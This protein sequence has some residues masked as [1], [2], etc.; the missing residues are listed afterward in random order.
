MAGFLHGFPWRLP[1]GRPGD[2]GLYGPGS[3]AW[4]VNGEAMLMLGGPRALLM[5]I[6][7]PAVAAAVAQFSGF[8]HDAFGR[9]WRTLET[10]LAVSFGDEEQARQA[11]ERVTA[12]HRGVRGRT[13][14]GAPFDALDPDLLLWVHATVVD[15]ALVV[16]DRFLS[17]LPE[18]VRDA[19]VL[20]MNRQ[21]VLFG[22][23]EEHLPR[24]A[25]E[26][27]AYV[28]RTIETLEVTDDARRLSPP[29]LRPPV[30][31]ALRPVARFQE[32]VTAGLLP[33]RLRGGYRIR[34][35]SGRERALTASERWI[36]AVVPRLPEVARRWPHLRAATRR[37]QAR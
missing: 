32:L 30:P 20:E 29:I 25:A 1:P 3:A 24:S 28:A 35:T 36:R 34:W 15:S 9:L 8:P 7:H 22:V 31:P 27:E 11:A 37:A 4:R 26:F 5:Q 17:R 12:V 2:R 6:A 10:M 13:V 14:A 19:Y 21:A 23:P 33:K 18:P 16:H